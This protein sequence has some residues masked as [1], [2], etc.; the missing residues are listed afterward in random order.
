MKAFDSVEHESIW[1]ALREQGVGE[2][3]IVLLSS[4]YKGQKGMVATDVRSKEFDIKRGTKQGDPLSTLLFNAVLE[5]I[6]AKLKVAWTSRRHGLDMSIGSKC[7]LSN[8]RFAD[9]VL[10]F[11]STQR[12]LRSMLTEL[13]DAAA[14]H[15]LK[16]HPDKTKILTNAPRHRVPSHVKLGE[17]DIEV[18]AADK[19]TKYLGRKVCIDRFHEVEL[20]NRIRAAWACFA[21]H[22]QELTGRQYALRDRLRL[23]DSTVSA[24]ALYGCE[25]WTLKEQDKRRLR[26]TQRKMLR[27]VLGTKRRLVRSQEGSST[28]SDGSS[29]PADGDESS[30]YALEPW[31][32]FL[33][34]ATRLVEQKTSELGMQEWLT[35]WRRRQWTWAQKLVKNGGHKWSHKALEWSPFLHASRGGVRPQARPKKRWS[36]DI[37]GYLNAKGISEPWTQLA[38]KSETWTELENDFLTYGLL[39][40]RT[41]SS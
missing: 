35:T 23:F 7:L 26:A 34:R 9:D 19:S 15:G 37:N 13:S 11:G 17:D 20:E 10:L 38:A 33:T 14:A 16:I 21:K 2:E 32:D 40:E 25:A 5:H 4:L 39:T 29:A 6:F 28:S 18:L 3:Y 12:Q 24:T 27:M 22:K 8:L 36:D 30:Q 1:Q 41:T 31:K